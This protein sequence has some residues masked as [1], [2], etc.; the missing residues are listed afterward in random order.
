LDE[1]GPPL[2]TVTQSN[3]QPFKIAFIGGSISAA[4]GASSRDKSLVPAVVTGL[5]TKSDPYVAAIPGANT[6]RLAARL[7]VPSD[8]ALVIIEAGTDD[9][10]AAK[11]PLNGFQQ[12]YAA[13][14]S[15]VRANAPESTILC[16]GV[17]QTGPEASAYD[18]AIRAE[19]EQSEGTFRILHDIYDSVGT[20]GPAGRPIF[21][22]GTKSDAILPN[23][24]GYRRIAARVVEA[25]HV[26]PA[27]TQ[28]R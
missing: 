27:I 17:W 10:G 11:T 25:V 4:I 22:K 2:A 7:S 6:A 26:Q 28:P 13:L 5:G 19:C 18:N 20:R 21:T 8:T 1:V 24:E 15:K 23:D 16:L 12:Q 14:V 9:S 3:S